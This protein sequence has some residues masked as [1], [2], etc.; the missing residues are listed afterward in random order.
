ME[1][2]FWAVGLC[3]KSH[4]SSCTVWV[5]SWSMAHP[6]AKIWP[7]CNTT[8]CDTLWSTFST[9]WMQLHR[10]SWNSKGTPCHRTTGKCQQQ[11][12]ELARAIWSSRSFLSYGSCVT[13]WSKRMTPHRVEWALQ[14][15]VI[16]LCLQQVSLG[17]PR[18]A[19]GPACITS[20]LLV[21]L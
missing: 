7:H 3:P 1:E 8:T 2:W 4:K 13:L 11:R 16:A 19:H 17:C 5:L 20:A 12:D 18:Q 21:F 14:P 9:G 15:Q 6:P 10:A